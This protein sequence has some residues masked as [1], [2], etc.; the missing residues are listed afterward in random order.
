M[1]HG[2]YINQGE[3]LTDVLKVRQLSLCDAQMDPAEDALDPEAVNIL[4]DLKDE[5]EE[6]TDPFIGCGRILCDV[7]QFRFYMELL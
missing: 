6:G 7:E 4:V 1:I 3:D 5:L 2:K